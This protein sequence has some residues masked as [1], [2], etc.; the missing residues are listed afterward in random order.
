MNRVFDYPEHPH[1]RRHGP[2]G[3]ADAASYR[4]WLRD[5]FAFRCVYCLCRESMGREIGEY[6]VDHF[7]P[8]SHRPDLG[9]EYDNL[10]YA[11]VPC[12]LRK[13][14]RFI[15][16]PLQFL[17]SGSVRVERDG[18]L[19]SSTRQAMQIIR[20][21]RLNS[22]DLV[23]FR[24]LWLDVLELCID[25][26]ALAKRILGF[27]DDLPELESLRPP[28]GNTRPEGLEHSYRRRRDRGELPDTY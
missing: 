10:L 20:V 14:D 16:D 26:P 1:V 17:V 5:E 6:A 23:E 3:Y 15:A 2:S 19:H 18:Q 9:T 24:R 11:C 4:V 8:T 27:P 28:G 21:L 22:A 13:G 12:N 25:Q 7:L